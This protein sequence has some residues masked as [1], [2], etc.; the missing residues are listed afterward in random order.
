[1]TR[2]G[3]MVFLYKMVPG[4][5]PKSYGMNVAQMANIPL[6]IV[7]RASQMASNFEES[8][9]NKSME[10]S[11]FTIGAMADRTN[12]QFLQLLVEDT[13]ERDVLIDFWKSLQ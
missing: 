3:T 4:P 11:G 7:A 8:V 9:E 10:R 2:S 13:L 1:M 12:K 5:C 6:S